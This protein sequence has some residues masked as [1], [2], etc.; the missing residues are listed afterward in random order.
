MDLR[1]TTVDDLPAMHA[2]FGDA[3]ASVFAPRGLEPPAMTLA[4]FSWIQAHL[5]ATG[6][7]RVAEE[8]GVV[9]G[10][11]SAWQ[12][13][14]DWFLGSLFVGPGAHG[15]GVGSRLLDSVWGEA[16][17]RRTITDAIQPVSNALYGR[18]GL[19][20]ATPVLTF[21]GVPDLAEPA[22]EAGADVAALDA[23]AYGFDRG[24]DH[25]AWQRIARLSTWRDAYSYSGRGH[26]G[27]VAGATP[28]AA[29]RALAAELTRA[30]GPVRVRIPGSSRAL[31]AVAL[32]AR[33]RLANAP[34][35]LLLSEGA[36]PPTALA[37]SGY[38]LY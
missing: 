11:A 24:V 14:D 1:P 2:I 4:A 17:R 19:I 23:A 20:P 28:A 5:L 10:Y 31:V 18:R 15:R 13:G 25:E 9:V 29:A 8:N 33:L 36:E 6:T 38:T 7:C 32:R 35:L 22:G 21:E 30:D 34:G 27:P 12:R 3:I 16:S 26:V 37:L